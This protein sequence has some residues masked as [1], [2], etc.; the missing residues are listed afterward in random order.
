MPFATG[1]SRSAPSP[2]PPLYFNCPPKFLEARRR[3][4][5]FYLR[6]ERSCWWRYPGICR[7]VSPYL[8][9]S[10]QWVGGYSI[11]SHLCLG[12]NHWHTTFWIVVTHFGV[13]ATNFEIRIAN[14]GHSF[15]GELTKAACRGY[16]GGW[17]GLST[18]ERAT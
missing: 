1:P 7:S 14:F 10:W 17:P 15:K 16:S 12:E 6:A 2:S 13:R 4:P 5:V 9:C 11:G 8:R 3:H 18:F